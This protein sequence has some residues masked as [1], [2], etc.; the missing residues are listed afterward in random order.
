MAITLDSGWLIA[1]DP[2]NVGRDQAWFRSPQPGAKATRVPS[3]LQE[4][5]PAYHGVVWYWLQFKPEPQPFVNGRYLLRFNSV[6]YLADVWLNSVHLGSHEGSETPFVL[7]ATDLIRPGTSNLLSLRVLNPDSEPIDG[8]VLAETPHRNKVVHFGTGNSFDYGG[9]LLPVEL[10]LTP[11][12]R[13]ASLHLRPDWKTG[14][15][16][17]ECALNNATPRTHTAQISFS[18]ARTTMD[19]PL[20][21]D[22]ASFPVPPGNSSMN[23]EV[24]INNHRLWEL[25]DP[26][27]YRLQ[28]RLQTAG[29][30]DVSE[31][32]TCFGFRD[33]RVV[34]GYFR[35]NDRRIFVKSTHTGNHVPLGQVVPPPGYPDLL[36]RDL[37][38]AKASGFNMVRYISGLAYPDELSLCDELGLLVYEETLAGLATRRFAK[39]EGAL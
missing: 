22:A 23:H 18:I 36:R 29:G 11:A 12:V 10:L 25:D 31:A 6:D 5:F 14:R 15:V 37:L 8:I 1:T 17:I 34:D 33:F 19:D 38:Y 30:E 20:L 39:D 4:T 21:A 7:D 27:L 35:L 32:S 28:A 13:I 16:Q 9:I 2:D 26:C 3:V 24:Q